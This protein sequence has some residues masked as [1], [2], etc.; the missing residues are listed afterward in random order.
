MKYQAVP[1][2][3]LVEA[4]QRTAESDYLGELYRRY[5]LR[6]YHY[7]LAV[8]HDPEEAFDKTQDIF[9]KAAVKL[10]SL[11]EPS[12]FSVWLFRIARNEC[13]DRAAEQRRRRAQPADYLPDMCTD[14]DDLESLL[15]KEQ[16]LDAIAELM[17][18][19]SEETRALLQLKY[20][21]NCSIRELQ[22]RYQ[23][24]ESAVKTRLSRARQRIAVLYARR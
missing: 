10:P 8:F 23:L 13:L 16:Q 14:Y 15:E 22:E 4:F 24:S 5:Y 21:S 3:C 18:E 12:T 6:V 20:L 17:T 7:C 19:L 11:R 1:D 9:L 2:Q